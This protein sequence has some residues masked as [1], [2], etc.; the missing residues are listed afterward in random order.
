MLHL[1]FPGAQYQGLAAL[2]DIHLLVQIFA[3]KAE[4]D[5]LILS[6]TLT[7]GI[8]RF[9]RRFFNALSILIHRIQ[10]PLVNE[11]LATLHEIVRAVAAGQTRR[12][13]LVL[14]PLKEH[15]PAQHEGFPV[16]VLVARLGEADGP[17][18]ALLEHD[19]PVHLHQGDVRLVP[20]LGDKLG[21]NDDILRPVRPFVIFIKIKFSEFLQA[22]KI[23][24]VRKR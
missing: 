11:P 3:G 9:R 15:A 2:G 19:G 21:M 7:R 10:R 23:Y 20:L 5:C 22:Y 4:K 18:L 13:V 24:T 16:L 17:H 8:L 12:R 14:I 1:L 6:L